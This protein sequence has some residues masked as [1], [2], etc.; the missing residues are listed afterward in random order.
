MEW[1]LA[2]P[3][4]LW[5]GWPFFVRALMS[6]VHRSSNM[7]TLIGLGVAIA[8]VY[9]VVATIAPHLFPA[10]FVEHGRV[11]VYFEAAAVISGIAP[12]V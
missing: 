12:R 11:G 1:A 10:S 3:V 5:D 8:Y 2:T 4:V 7:W 6:I 9:S